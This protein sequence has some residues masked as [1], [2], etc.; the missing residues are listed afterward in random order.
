M[1]SPGCDYFFSQLRDEVNYIQMKHNLEKSVSYF[2]EKEQFNEVQKIVDRQIFEN[3]KD[4]IRYFVYTINHFSEKIKNPS[5]NPNYKIEMIKNL[6]EDMIRNK[7]II[8]RFPLFED[9]FIDMIMRFSHNEAWGYKTSLDYLV[10][11]FRRN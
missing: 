6:V 3:N 10:C 7:K 5:I 8:K 11:Y 4:C 2:L 9:S 1:N